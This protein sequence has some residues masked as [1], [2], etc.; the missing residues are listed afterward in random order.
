MRITAAVAE[1]RG[2]AL[3]IEELELEPPRADEVLVRLA[4]SGICHADSL[5]RDGDLPFPLAGVL[6]HEGAG[7]IVELGSAVTTL[8]VGD[9]VV[10]SMPWCG[11]CPACL[12]GQPRYCRWVLDLIAGGGRRDGSTS[13]RRPG[14]SPLHSHFFGQSSFA[15][16]CVV[17]ANQAVRVDPRVDL[18][19][20]GHIGCGV[21][22]GAGAVLNVLAPPPGSSLVVFGVGTVGLAAIMAARCTSAT[23]IVAVDRNPE[24]LRLAVELGATT[25]IRAQ[26][27]DDLAGRV[28]EACGGPA[29]RTLECTGSV[30]VLRA[31]VDS[32]G[33]LGVCG[34]VGGAP[35]GAE[36]RL[37]HHTTMI[38]KRI[39]GIH[40]GEGRSPELIG[41]ILG[42]HAQGR[43]PVERLVTS[44]PL[45]RAEEAIRAAER[46]DVVKAVLAMPGAA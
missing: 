17:R 41:A 8:A 43:M 3:R 33:M 6:G 23:T 39:V 13:L 31:A 38:G 5:A 42:L 26:P 45:E 24:R 14:G 22:T 16:H 37:D 40:G 21:A 44:F 25:A 15:T 36:I 10:L 7:E 34:L 19:L 11:E 9:R 46:G 18:G 27:G 32:I 30:D 20:V 28:R 35:A 1:R 29:D 12:G 2:G 4:S